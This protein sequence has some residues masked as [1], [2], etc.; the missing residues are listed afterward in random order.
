MRVNK[1]KI[2]HLSTDRQL[3]SIQYIIHLLV[4]YYYLDIVSL[5]IYLHVKIEVA[6]YSLQRRYLSFE[7]LICVKIPWPDCIILSKNVEEVK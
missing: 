7:Y 6:G 3:Y 1:R 2:V 5:F 4:H